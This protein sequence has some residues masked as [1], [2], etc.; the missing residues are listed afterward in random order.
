M[1]I[2]YDHSV[3]Q[4]QQYGGVSR[5]FYEIITRMSTKKEVEIDLFQG[6]HVNE[7]DLQSKKS[8]FNSYSGIN[9]HL[10]ISSLIRSHLFIAP[11]KVLFDRFYKK[12]KADVYH[13]TF[14]YKGMKKH[15]KMPIVLTVYDMIHEVFPNQLRYS[16]YFIAAKKASIKAADV[17]ICISNNTKK[18]LME[19]HNVPEE[20]IRVVYLASSLQKNI[21]T[22]IYKS[23]FDKPYLLYV[24][25]R[26]GVYKNFPT[27]LDAFVSSLK[28]EYKLFCFGGG[29][30]N[31][32][33]IDIIDRARCE[34][35]VIQLSG[36]DHVLVS[37]YAGAYAFICPSFY[38]GFGLPL[39]EAMGMGCPVIAAN[40][41]SIPEVVGDAAILFNPKYKNELIEAVGNVNGR[42][43]EL[44]EAG[45]TQEAKFS[46]EKTAKKTLEI[47]K[48]V[49]Q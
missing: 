27:L 33:E 4:N 7:Y 45:I 2:L 44:I 43:D 29:P 15:H 25:D 26:N 14:Y 5:Y 20:K 28:D 30:F 9:P 21:N 47:Y 11:N 31:K 37:L 22:P 38:E 42:R 12:S 10:P 16:S 19:I 41:S 46:W 3:F 34:D 39:L 18:D 17:I 40:T 1:R 24:G 36:S 32:D 23:K 35:K 48:E 13:P 8:S 49:L 6:L